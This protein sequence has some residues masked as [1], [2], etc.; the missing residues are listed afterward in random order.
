MRQIRTL[1]RLPRRVCGDAEEQRKERNL[2]DRMLR[3]KSKNEFSGTQ[4]AE[5]SAFAVAA[6]GN[7]HEADAAPDPLDPFADEAANRLEQDILMVTRG[8]RTRALLSRLHRY[9]QCVNH[10]LLQQEPVVQQYKEKIK[11]ASVAA[12]G[13]PQ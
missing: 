13:L 3:A 6:H 1:G 7:L 10:D 2:A 12:P 8:F 5:L 4:L 9:K 11:A